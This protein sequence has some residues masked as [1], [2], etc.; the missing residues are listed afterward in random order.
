MSD[1]TL[2]VRGL[3]LLRD[4]SGDKNTYT[5]DDHTRAGLPMLVAC[6]GCQTTMAGASAFIDLN[7]QLWCGDCAD[8]DGDLPQVYRNPLVGGEPGA[9]KAHLPTRPGEVDR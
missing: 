7:D 5:S 8:P 3:D 9:G 1:S 6:T 4:A 2:Y